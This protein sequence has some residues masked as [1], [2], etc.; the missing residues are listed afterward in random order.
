MGKNKKRFDETLQEIREHTKDIKR[1]YRLRQQEDEDAIQRLKD[2]L[3]KK[4]ENEDR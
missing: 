3:K 1:R 2:Y 4:D